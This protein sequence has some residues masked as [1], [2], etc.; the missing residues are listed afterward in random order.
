MRGRVGV[1]VWICEH[2][3]VI[4]INSYYDI[5]EV[6]S[7][8]A[9]LDDHVGHIPFHD[10]VFVIEVQ[11]GHGAEF[12]W[13]AAGVHGSRTHSSHAVLVHD[14]RVERRSRS[15]NSGHVRR[16]IPF[17]IIPKVPWRGDDPVV[18]ADVAEIDVKLLAATQTAAAVAFKASFADAVFVVGRSRLDHKEWTVGFIGHVH[19]NRNDTHLIAH[20]APYV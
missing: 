7:A 15:G 11:H 3:W 4:N 2:G 20:F 12:G 5:L 6:S 18:P 10:V 16:T 9:L 1:C 17:T 14:G 8:A 13:D 19:Q